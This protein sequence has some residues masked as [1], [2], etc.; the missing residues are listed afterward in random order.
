[1]RDVKN[2]KGT[3]RLVLVKFREAASAARFSASSFTED[4]LPAIRSLGT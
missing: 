3:I 2:G 1:M 4:C